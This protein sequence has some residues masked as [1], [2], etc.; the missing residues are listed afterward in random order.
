[1]RVYA[2]SGWRSVAW[3]LGSIA[4]AVAG[5]AV[6]ARAGH[7][8][9]GCR[10]AHLALSLRASA[11]RL[12]DVSC[13]I[14]TDDLHESYQVDVVAALLY[15][16][17]LAAVLL[18]WWR[19]GWRSRR[20]GSF[21]TARVAAC[22]PL[23]AAAFDVLENAG[24]LWWVDV[25]DSRLAV[26]RLVV[27]VLAAFGTAKWVLVG[28]TVVLVFLTIYGA[29][30]FSGIKVWDVDRETGELSPPPPTETRT[31]GRQELQETL[32]VCLSGG[33]IRSAAF[34]WGAMAMLEDAGRLQE[35]TTL[36]TVSGGGY[37]AASL[38]NQRGFA[39]PYFAVDQGLDAEPKQPAT[40]YQFV[41]RHRHY[42]DNLRGGVVRAAARTIMALGLNLLV[43]A[44][45]LFVLAAPVGW[46][47]RSDHGSVQF[48]ATD[49]DGLRATLRA[50]AWW[51]TLLVGGLVL[52]AIAVACFVDDRPRRRSVLVAAL[53]AAALA[54][55]IFVV[56][57]GLPVLAAE[58]SRIAE[59]DVKAL[60][61]AALTWVVGIA[62]AMLKSWLPKVAV[63]LGGLVVAVAML[64]TAAFF[65]EWVAVSELFAP[66]ENAAAGLG[67][68]V[69]FLVAV[70]FTGVQWWS[71]HPVY[72]DR[73]ARTFV[74]QCGPSIG[75][76]RWTDW[77][78][79]SELPV[80]GGRPKHVVC[81]ATHRSDTI[82][83]G[84]RSVSFRFSADGVEYFVP[85]V[86]EGHL[87]VDR[88]WRSAEW[89][90]RAVKDPPARSRRANARSTV[91][92]AAAMSGAAFN[93]VMGRQSR[94]STDSLLAVL[95]LRLGVWLPN[96]RFE[97]EPGRSFPRA[98][99]RY[100][101][102]E[103]FGILDVEDPF[104]HV[105]DGGH[106]EN[107][108]LVEALRDRHR[109]VILVDASGGRVA[110]SSSDP[111]APGFG[112]LYEAIDLAR[113]EL[114]VEV[115]IDVSDLR[116]DART[117]RARTNVARGVVVYHS[118]AS[119]SWA[120]CACPRGSLL[121]VKAVVSDT[122]PEDVLLHANVDRTFPHYS[123][124]DQFLSGEEF[125]ALARLG[126]SATRRA[127]R[128]RDEAST[129]SSP[130]AADGALTAVE[131]P[132]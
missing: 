123:T 109:H 25:D 23:A 69:A 115:R 92:G 77:A 24:V 97:T 19:F 47:A 21:R 105:S 98:G 44:A 37:T 117:G 7:L 113:I 9:R 71:M 126:E 87:V 54:T 49:S 101:F 96:Q 12:S 82:G 13:A 43:I 118:D 64:Y 72:R 127:L 107:L 79:W 78:R 8:A 122:T 59:H 45:G 84:L 39:S 81:A 26:P 65:V 120:L 129:A 48:S 33:G 5:L 102:H 4:A 114:Q 3:R 35:S 16:P 88:Y 29:I 60:V 62:V 103:V 55:G 42:L 85:R 99:L 6:V 28:L 14:T 83:T 76:Q 2:A 1:M 91:I 94:G 66:W 89:L 36:Y 41:R 17:A 104:V 56:A 80:G 67:V 95:N 100:L 125:H 10:D 38:T 20:H 40:P 15:G 86:D 73:L 52:V 11:G 32:A 111:N 110:P 68:G 131:Q 106:W 53:A 128:G 70:D 31:Q 27:P 46:L 116:P 121:Y 75:P 112:G 74:I 18:A 130:G 93:S 30:R 124:A 50:G 34:A 90:E 58:R 51:P 57:I 119:H 108:G 61:P 132:K 22:V 63:R